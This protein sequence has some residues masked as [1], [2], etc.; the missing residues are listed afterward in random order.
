[1]LRK[2]PLT[3]ALEKILAGSGEC[4][5]AG[6]TFLGLTIAGWSLVWFVLLGALTLYLLWLGRA[7][8]AQ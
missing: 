2:F 1:M 8:G 7:R 6:W 3:R 5:E 4:A